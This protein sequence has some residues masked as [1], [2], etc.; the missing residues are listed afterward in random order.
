[1]KIILFVSVLF[2]SH[3][4]VA[5]SI[6][7][8]PKMFRLSED[9]AILVFEGSWKLV[10]K[11]PT[12][13]IPAA[14]SFRIECSRSERICREYVAK[15][16]RPSDDPL[17][18]VKQTALF[19]MHQEFV[20]QGWDNNRILAKAKTRAADIFLRINLTQRSGERESMETEQRGALGAR[21]TSDKWVS[22]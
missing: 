2:F 20:I 12:V 14:N 21:T 9:E 13:E 15:L 6:A 19:M 7:T 22:N 4:V 1:M 3:I 10:T 17:K 16:I 18:A 8:N 5:E 11:R